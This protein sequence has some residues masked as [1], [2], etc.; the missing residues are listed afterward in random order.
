MAPANAQESIAIRITALPPLDLRA[1]I[2]ICVA[3]ADTARYRRAGFVG[4][5]RIADPH[6]MVRTWPPRLPLMSVA[7]PEM[8][9]ALPERID[10][11]HSSSLAA[12]L[13]S[14]AACLSLRGRRSAR[15]RSGPCALGDIRPVY[16]EVLADRTQGPLLGSHLIPGH[17]DSMPSPSAH[18]SPSESDQNLTIAWNL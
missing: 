15:G 1:A 6:V 14:S 12:E 5:T 16:C 10:K 13:Y 8:F 18:R 2:Q 9:V 7:R 11:T 3:P 17:R 4:R